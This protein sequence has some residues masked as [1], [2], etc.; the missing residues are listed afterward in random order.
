MGDAFGVRAVRGQQTQYEQ[1]QPKE[2]QRTTKVRGPQNT[3][4]WPRR[5]H[6]VMIAG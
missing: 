6:A 3:D 4:G 5:N 1:G 2:V